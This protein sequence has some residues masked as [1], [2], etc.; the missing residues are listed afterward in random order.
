[1]HSHGTRVAG[2]VLVYTNN[3]PPIYRTISYFPDSLRI[4]MRYNQ[5]FT[6]TGA[7]A[8]VQAFRGNSVYDPDR[9]GTGSQPMYYDQLSSIYNK[10]VVLGARCTLTVANASGNS[11]NVNVFPSK[12]TTFAGAMYD[13]NQ[14]PRASYGVVSPNSGANNQC[15]L[16]TYDTLA[17]IYGKV[18]PEDD[19]NY[20]SQV[21]TNPAQGWNFLMAA[22]TFDGTTTVLYSNVTID[23]DVLWTNRNGV[24]DV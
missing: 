17:R 18:D 24:F 1:V 3:N 11:V 22:Q 19:D 5:V 8:V 20:G 23:Y 21:G 14:Q 16:C 9:T 12:D 2:S 7:A 4:V 15:F 10:Y 13:R 6:W